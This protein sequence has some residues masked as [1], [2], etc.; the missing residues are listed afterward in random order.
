[1]EELVKEYK[2]VKGAL[3]WW[4]NAN[5][6]FFEERNE[7]ENDNPSF[8]DID[9]YRFLKEFLMKH[10]PTFPISSVCCNYAK[11][12]VVKSI[13]E[14]SNYDLQIIGVRKSEAGIR[15][16]S[17]K[18]CYSTDTET[19]QYRPLFW[20]KNEDKAYY[21][22]IFNIKHSRCYY[23]Y[24]FKR[25]GCV[26]CPY[27]KQLNYSLNKTKQY[28]PVLYKAVN[29]IFKDSYEYTRLYKAFI[30]EKKLGKTFNKLF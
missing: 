10:P 20:F 5:K 3:N 16:K 24:G 8:Y 29:N 17:Y 13:L 1:M 26:C 12:K 9:Y 25:T 22:K 11:K 2:H 4:C 7:D 18:N 28:E 21:D 23:I 15:G 19:H 27:G 14:N 30:K 6:K